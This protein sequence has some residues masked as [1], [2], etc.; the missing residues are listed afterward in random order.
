MF[1]E[2]LPDIIIQYLYEMTLL[3]EILMLSCQKTTRGS[4]KQP[5]VTLFIWRE[6]ASTHI[7]AASH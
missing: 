4:V 2:R 1:D 3:D 7:F 5:I 6:E